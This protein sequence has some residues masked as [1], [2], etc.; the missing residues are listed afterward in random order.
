M[1]SRALLLKWGKRKTLHHLC[2]RA[3]DQGWLRKKWTIEFAQRGTIMKKK[4]VGPVP[5]DGGFSIGVITK[6]KWTM[7]VEEGR[8][9]V[10]G[11]KEP[12]HLGR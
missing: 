10:E 4:L 12:S 11:L 9:W 7:F 3:Q 6:S 1:E 2:L 8:Q 5:K